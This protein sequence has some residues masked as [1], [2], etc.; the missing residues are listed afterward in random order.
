MKLNKRYAIYHLRWQISAWV[1]LPVM[2]FLES[3]VPLWANLMIGQFVGALIFWW[4]DKRIFKHHDEDTLESEMN[5]AYKVEAPNI[6]VDQKK[7]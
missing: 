3:I 2:L 5:I 6:S 7:I 1:M 4:I